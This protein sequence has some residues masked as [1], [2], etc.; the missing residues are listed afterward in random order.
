MWA[1]LRAYPKKSSA[2]MKKPRRVRTDQVSLR[3]SAKGRTASSVWS[4]FTLSVPTVI[5]PTAQASASSR[6]DLPQPFSPTKKVT[7]AVNS[8][9]SSD[10]MTGTVKGKRSGRG[11][12]RF[13]AME[14]RWMPLVCFISTLFTVGA[15][16]GRLTSAVVAHWADTRPAP[17]NGLPPSERTPWPFPRR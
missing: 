17:T 10:W 15:I 3:H 7:W 13:R 2:R 1:I 5:E 16:V 14:R 8:S 4:A 12:A 9:R 11:S 6:V